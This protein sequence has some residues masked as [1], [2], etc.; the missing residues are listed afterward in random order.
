MFLCL[1]RLAPAICEEIRW[2]TCDSGS[3][4]VVIESMDTLPNEL[5][6]FGAAALATYSGGSF[7]LSRLPSDNIALDPRSEVRYLLSSAMRTPCHFEKFAQGLVPQGEPPPDILKAI[8][9]AVRRVLGGRAYIQLVGSATKRKHFGE[10]DHDYHIRV[11]DGWFASAQ[12]VTRMQMLQIEESLDGGEIDAK[13]GFSA[14]IV[15]YQH[16][17]TCGSIDVAPFDGDVAPFG[18]FLGRR[19]VLPAGVQAGDRHDM[20]RQNAARVLKWV[21]LKLDWKLRSLYLEYVLRHVDELDL[22]TDRSG[23][24]LFKKAMLQF[25]L[26]WPRDFWPPE[27]LQQLRSHRCHDPKP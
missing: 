10:S 14:L 12:P 8:A 21:A 27:M 20:R 9:A 24:R 6:T 3:K 18:N 19:A 1:T 11:P 25:Q 5:V 23:L 15:H 4:C 26:R 17:N 7:L 2:H 16:G 22:Q 13:M